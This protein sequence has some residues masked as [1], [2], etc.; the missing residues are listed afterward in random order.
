[1]K[2]ITIY[3]VIFFIASC[4]LSFGRE[5]KNSSSN[6]PKAPPTVFGCPATTAQTDL[7]LNNV[8]AHILNGG[9]L[10]WD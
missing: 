8:R 9:D 3:T 4:Y 2:K 10:W 6:K 5:N 7:N 1:M